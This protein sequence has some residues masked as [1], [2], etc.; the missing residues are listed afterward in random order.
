MY[1]KL[2]QGDECSLTHVE[3]PD[4]TGHVVVLKE[5][6][7]DLLGKVLLVQHQETVALL[8]TINT[9]ITVRDLA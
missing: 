5:L 3:L 1:H 4:E 9:T 7:E 6:G 2:R 8:K